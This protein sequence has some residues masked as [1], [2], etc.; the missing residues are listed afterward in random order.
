MRNVEV[1]VELLGRVLIRMGLRFRPGMEG[2]A[3]DMRPVVR[4][5]AGT[6]LQQTL[7]SFEERTGRK[8][9]EFG[10]NGTDLLILG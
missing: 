3:Y 8:P 5:Q 9:V 4:S 2:R 1:D 10:L 6:W 7:E